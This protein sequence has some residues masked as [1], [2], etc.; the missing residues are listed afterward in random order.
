MLILMLIL[1]VCIHEWAHGYVAY[2]LGDKTAF[3][4][5]RLSLNPLRHIDVVGSLLVPCLLVMS[6]TQFVFGWAKPVPVN[7]QYFKRPNYDMLLVAMAGPLVNFLLAIVMVMIMKFM[8]YSSFFVFVTDSMMKVCLFF[9]Y[10]N[11]V[12]AIFNLIPIPPLDGS[13]LFLHLIPLKYRDIIYQYSIFGLLLVVCLL[14]LS[15]VQSLFHMGVNKIVSFLVSF[16]LGNLF[17]YAIFLLFF[18]FYT[19]GYKGYFMDLII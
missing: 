16:K 4:L 3:Y 18:S 15:A 13:Y 17:Y 7:T 14:S 10:I 12:L 6:G 19:I 11:V 5:K 9:V 2:L 8:I 1:S